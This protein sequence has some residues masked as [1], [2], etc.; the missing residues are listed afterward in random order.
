MGKQL[1]RL[2]NLAAPRTSKLLPDRPLVSVSIPFDSKVVNDPGKEKWIMPAMYFH[3][4]W[5]A[6]QGTERR[7]VCD[8]ALIADSEGWRSAFRTDVDHDSEVMPISVPN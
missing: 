4:P 1:E 6:F 3:I 5:K 2:Q 8:P 7:T